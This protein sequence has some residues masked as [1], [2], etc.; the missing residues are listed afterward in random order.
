MDIMMLFKSAAAVSD[1]TMSD[2]AGPSAS[3]H[4]ERDDDSR[5]IAEEISARSREL[6]LNR[7]LEP[8]WLR[9]QR[10]KMRREL[11]ALLAGT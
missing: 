4:V 7:D 10:G 3:T 8:D 9:G 11:V 6:Y 5:E 2:K 1:D